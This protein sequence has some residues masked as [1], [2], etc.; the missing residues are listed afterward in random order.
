[1]LKNPAFKGFFQFLQLVI[2]FYNFPVEW[3]KKWCNHQ[4]K[5]VC[6]QNRFYKIFLCFQ[7]AI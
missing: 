3:C 4:N 7:I 1:M 5:T 6:K 2:A